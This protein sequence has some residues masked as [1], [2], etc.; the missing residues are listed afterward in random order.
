MFYRYLTQHCWLIARGRTHLFDSFASQ[1]KGW[2]QKWF[3]FWQHCV[4]VV[5]TG[6]LTISFLHISITQKNLKRREKKG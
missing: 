4:V 1:L 2:G 3:D 6:Q 5:N